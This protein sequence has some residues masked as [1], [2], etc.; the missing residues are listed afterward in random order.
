MPTLQITLSDEAL[1]AA[2][3]RAAEGGLTSV[4]AYLTRLIEADAAVPIS[5][6]LEAELLK[7]LE[8]EAIPY[9]SIDWEQEKRDL[10]AWHAS[11][12]KP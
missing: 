4:D 10:I 11:T 7:G 12:Q 1:D 5:A 3:S 8:G 2:R 9:A 6:A